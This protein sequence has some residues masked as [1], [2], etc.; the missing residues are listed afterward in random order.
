MFFFSRREMEMLIIKHSI[1]DDD[2][3]REKYQK[4]KNLVVFVIN[5]YFDVLFFRS[6]SLS[7]IICL[8]DCQ[9]NLTNL[10]TF[11]FNTIS[12]VRFLSYPNDDDDNDDCCI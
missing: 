11:K 7:L 12:S 6:L 4:I 10:L 1:R 2:D 9:S 5:N 3:I 8:R